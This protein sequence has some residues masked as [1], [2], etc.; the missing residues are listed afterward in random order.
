MTKYARFKNCEKQTNKQT[1]QNCI[2]TTTQEDC[3]ACLF[4]GVHAA[5]WSVFKP[6]H[7]VSVRRRKIS[8]CPFEKCT[9]LGLKSMRF[10]YSVFK[11][12]RFQLPFLLSLSHTVY[13]SLSHTHTLSDHGCQ[14]IYPSIYL[15]IYLS[16]Y[17]SMYLSV[18][19]YI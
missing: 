19:L 4:V 5:C 14:S 12:Y 13:L 9:N 3:I 10:G 2:K 1:K 6:G 15:L 16:A 17:L 18:Y 8:K 7:T 11:M